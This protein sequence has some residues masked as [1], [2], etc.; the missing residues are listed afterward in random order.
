ML[1]F[2]FIRVHFNRFICPLG[3][4]HSGAVKHSV[5]EINHEILLRPFSPLP[6]IQEGQLPVSGE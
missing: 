4:V 6:L 2:V 5:G 1:I 3:I